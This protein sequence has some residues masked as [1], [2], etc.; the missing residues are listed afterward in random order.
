MVA[1]LLSVAG[2]N[3]VIT[4]DLH[5]T[6]IQNFFQCPVDNLR[7]EPLLAK[8][9]KHNVEDW[10]EGVVVSKNPGGTKRVTSLADAL[11]VNFGIVTT[12]R[13]R[14]LSA[15]DMWY[16][17]GVIGFTGSPN[18]APGRGSD[19]DG[20][21][22]EDEEEEEINGTE[23]TASLQ[24]GTTTVAEEEDEIG[25]SPAGPPEVHL[26]SRPGSSLATR[27]AVDRRR[28]TTSTPLRGRMNQIP[29]SPLAR[30]TLVTGS[31]ERS[32]LLSRVVT[33]PAG[34][35]EVQNEEFTDEVRR[36]PLVV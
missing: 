15:V 35:L 11:K 27:P 8:W 28:T 2:V 7:A 29:S 21:E 30:S 13:R 5:A 22:P 31:P 32:D 24:N 4:V 25:S 1:N 18:Y 23:D 12:D 36:L 9:I 17:S 20:F 6:Q 26:P 14:V 19:E 10:S 3:H 33:A 34:T 16:G